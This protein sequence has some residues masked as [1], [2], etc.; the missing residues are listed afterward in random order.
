MADP[1]EMIPIV[2]LG[3]Y[4]AGAS[5]A[6]AAAAGRIATALE[7]IGF[8]GISN[9]GVPEEV[10]AKAFAASRAFRAAVSP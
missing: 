3:P 9:H 10:V 4:R 5:G 1:G 7:T 8:F 6:R 2:D